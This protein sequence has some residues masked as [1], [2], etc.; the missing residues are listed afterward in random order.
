MRATCHQGE[1]SLHD[2]L[3]EH[4]ITISK[5]W[6]RLYE[7]PMIINAWKMKSEKSP[8]DD[9]DHQSMTFIILEEEEA[10]LGPLGRV[11]ISFI[12]ETSPFFK[13]K[14]LSCFKSWSRAS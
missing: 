5:T 3:C 11:E 14:H 7:H 9:I 4:P 8:I 12:E 6:D 10:G 13:L 2:R 1:G